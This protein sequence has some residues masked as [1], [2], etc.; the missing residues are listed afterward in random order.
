M[1]EVVAILA[2]LV[3]REDRQR[4]TFQ[5]VQ[6]SV[7][8]NRP[9]QIRSVRGKLLR[10]LDDPFVGFRIAHLANSQT[11]AGDVAVSNLQMMVGAVQSLGQIVQ[12]KSAFQFDPRI[13]TFGDDRILVS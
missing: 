1:I 9:R 12:E 5:R 3:R 13:L 10:E 2:N 7:R 4:L 8:N 6:I 11:R